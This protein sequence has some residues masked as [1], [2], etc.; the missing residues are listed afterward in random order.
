MDKYNLWKNIIFRE[1]F[2][3]RKNDFN[4]IHIISSNNNITWEIVRDNQDKP[5]NWN[6]LS[7][8]PNSIPYMLFFKNKLEYNE[9]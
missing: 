6:Y 1:V 8:N 5:W 7:L 3:T 4:F 2:E 9:K